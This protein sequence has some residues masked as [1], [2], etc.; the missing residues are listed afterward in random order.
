MTAGEVRV[1]PEAVE[2]AVRGLAEIKSA[3]DDVAAFAAREALAAQ[4]FGPLAA[5]FGAGEAVVGAVAA[6][7][8]SFARSVPVLAELAD[9]LAEQAK[10]VVEVDAEAAAAI[11]RAGGG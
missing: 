10:R 7:R 3:V 1:D 2:R 6:L 4:Q 5:R 9:G 11:R 8:E